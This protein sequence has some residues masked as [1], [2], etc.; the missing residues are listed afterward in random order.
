MGNG[1]CER[2]NRTLLE[3][4]GTL[5]TDQKV[6]WKTYVAPL[7]HMYNS[8]QHDTTG[9]SPYFLLFGRE[10][11]LPIDLLLPSPAVTGWKTLSGYIA[12]LRERLRHAHE[13]VQARLKG[14]GEAS[15]KWYAKKVRGATLQLGDQVLLR[16]I[17]LQ[18]KNK[19]ADRWQ[20][21]VY[22]V[23]SQ[24]NAS[25]PVFSVRRLDGRGKVKTVHRNLLLPVRSVPTPIPSKPK[26]VLSQTPIMTRSRTRLR[27]INDRAPRSDSSPE[28]VQSH[29]TVSTVVPQP[30]T[31]VVAWKA[32]SSLDLDEDVTSV[33]LD[34][35]VVRSED[36]GTADRSSEGG[37]QEADI[38]ESDSEMDPG[39]ESTGQMRLSP[40]GPSNSGTGSVP[41]SS[42]EVRPR[43]IVRPRRQPGWMRSGEWDVG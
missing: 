27:D 15:Q 17:G 37:D 33:L 43:R 13:V 41:F 19:L 14:K 34:E 25:I 7:V 39:N 31:S 24:P 12:A 3:M 40:D 8:T 18:G 11:R 20:E 5:E 38:S 9:F 6:D 30:Q 4:L 29:D 28:S 42:T 36:G 21:E 32:D 35:S 26:S 16:Q 10:P 1:Q 23:T 2:F 22:V